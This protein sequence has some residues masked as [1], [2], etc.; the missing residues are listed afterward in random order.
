LLQVVS[1]NV[2]SSDS[3]RAVI[4]NQERSFYFEYLLFKFT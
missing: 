4:P 1:G 2:D 3:F